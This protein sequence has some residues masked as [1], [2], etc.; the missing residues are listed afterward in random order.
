MA[1]INLVYI[2]DVDKTTGIDYQGLRVNKQF[3]TRQ[4]ECGELRVLTIYAAL[5]CV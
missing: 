2:I 1:L 5:S 4:L 3:V